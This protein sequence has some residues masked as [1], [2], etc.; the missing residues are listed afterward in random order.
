MWKYNE[1]SNLPN[2]SLYYNADEF[3]HYGVLGMKWGHHKK[4][5][6]KKN[7]QR[8][9]A[10]ISKGST[11]E[12]DRYYKNQRKNM[13]KM[14]IGSNMTYAGLGIGA[15]ALKCKPNNVS[16]SKKRKAALLVSGIL[17][18]TG[19][20]IVGKGIHDERKNIYNNR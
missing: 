1:T 16:E 6:V 11:S 2:T 19:S 3:Y 8:P 5:T 18:I 14:R 7:I 9:K 15:F 10:R 20:A 17:S 12:V 4:G 13:L